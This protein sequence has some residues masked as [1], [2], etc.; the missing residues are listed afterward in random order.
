M[1]KSDS[2]LYKR[3]KPENKFIAI[4]SQI[5][6]LVVFISVAYFIHSSSLKTS[7]T[8]KIEFSRR[9]SLDIVEDLK[10]NLRIKKIERHLND[11]T[12][13]YILTTEV[14]DPKQTSS[15]LFENNKYIWISDKNELKIRGSEP[16]NDIMH[17]FEND[18]FPVSVGDFFV[19]D[20]A[21]LMIR[22]YN[23]KHL[24]KFSY[25]FEN[26]AYL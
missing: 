24:F 20:S 14:F 1:I 4:I 23:H 21:S 9:H 12:S 15:L 18:E 6:G 8:R 26:R 13:D 11:R 5:G 10:W 3:E 22:I 17:N 2:D 19:K 16:A 25:L 7:D